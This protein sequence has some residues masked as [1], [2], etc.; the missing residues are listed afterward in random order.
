MRKPYDSIGCL[1]AVFMRELRRMCSRPI[2]FFCVVVAPLF[3]LFFFTSLLDEGLPHRLPVGVVD[4][5]GSAQS[6]QV[7]RTLDAMDQIEVCRIYKNYADA[8]DAVQRGEIYA[9]LMIP[10]NFANDLQGFRQPVLTY[11]VSYTYYV[12]GSLTYSSLRKLT[13]LVSG[14]ALRSSLSAKGVGEEQ[15]MAQL[16]PIVIEAHAL[17][18]PSLNYAIYLNNTIVPGL[19]MLLISLMTVYAVGS[20]VKFNTA[21]SWL[22]KS[23]HSILLALFSKLL[24]YTLAFMVI[25]LFADYYM[26]GILQYPC[27]GG[28]WPTVILTLFMVLSAQALGLLFFA[29]IPVLRMALSLCSL[30]GVVSFSIC[31]FSFPQPAMEAPVRALSWL[32]PL[33]HYYLIYVSQTLDGNSPLYSFTNYAAL[34]VFMLLPLLLLVRLKRALIHTDYIP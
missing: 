26:Y 29:A 14:A 5:D 10:S 19:M 9:F 4:L 6:R 28:L 1:R 32:F 2:Y 20:E 33:R 31:G 34:L 23:N 17:R 24:P 13:E 27:E 25:A 22:E 12:A 30:W 8:R 11:Y 15:M 18:N 7:V 21:R 16:Q 3:S